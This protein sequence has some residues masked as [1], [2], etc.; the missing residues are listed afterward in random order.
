[1]V[2]HEE[3]GFRIKCL[4]KYRADI[5]VACQLHTAPKHI[6]GNDLHTS[7]GECCDLPMYSSLN[8]YVN[9][10]DGKQSLPI[11]AADWCIACGGRAGV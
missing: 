8:C 1:M 2:T 7:Y 11:L 9:V 6:Y 4:G 5:Y 10:T 3:Q